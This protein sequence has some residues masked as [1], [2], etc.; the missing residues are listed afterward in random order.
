MIYLFDTTGNWIAF[1]KDNYLFNTSC[2]WIGWFPY[3]DDK[4]IAVD[5][6]GSYLGTIYGNRLLYNLHQLFLPYPGYPG[7]PGFPGYP[8]YPGFAGFSGFIPE[9]KDIDK[10][11]LQEK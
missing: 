10:S 6:N 9:T 11:K 1:K 2:E 7:Y 8:G 4:N 5:I 3:S